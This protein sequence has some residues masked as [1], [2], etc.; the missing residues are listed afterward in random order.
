[1]IPDI[2]RFQINIIIQDFLNI[3]FVNELFLM[4]L[5]IIDV[6]R[7]ALTGEYSYLQNRVIT[8]LMLKANEDFV[9]SQNVANTLLVSL[10][11]IYNPYTLNEHCLIIMFTHE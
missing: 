5:R 9:L 2:F 8:M 6:F 10:P 11:N 4:I 7:R 3:L 1:M